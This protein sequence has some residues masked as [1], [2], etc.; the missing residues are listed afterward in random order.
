MRNNNYE[1]MFVFKPTLN[2]DQ[3]NSLL[4]NVRDLIAKN[5]GEILDTQNFGRRKLAYDI[6]KHR[7]GLYY[8]INFKGQGQSIVKLEKAYRSNDSV[9]RTMIIKR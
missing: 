5:G 8:L 3:T 4:D 6:M 9:L 2:D 7:E 1:A